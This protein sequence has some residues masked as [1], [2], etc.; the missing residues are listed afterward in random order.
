MGEKTGFLNK[1]HR[2]GEIIVFI[3]SIE[4][5]ER[6]RPA[7][8]SGNVEKTMTAP[9]CAIIGY[10][11]SCWKNLEKLYPF[12]DMSQLFTENPQLL[13]QLPFEMALCRGHILF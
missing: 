1:E 4:A 12:K 10:D 3:K 5:K 8:V 6:L 11:V 2:V 13:K 7:L 9:V